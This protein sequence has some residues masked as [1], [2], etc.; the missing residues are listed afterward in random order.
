MV[1]LEDGAAVGW[2]E[3]ELTDP[4]TPERAYDRAWAR[5]VMRCALERLA[6]EHR[7]P[8]QARL[9]DA[10]QPMLVDGGRVRR[11]AELAASLGMS[12]GAIAVAATRLRRRYRTLIEAEVRR[13]LADPADLEG[14]MRSL[15]EAWE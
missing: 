5:Q 12:A 11:E 14:E 9:F 3:Q 8:P 7:T 10:L 4:M 6:G 13:T 15:W 2:L 1:S